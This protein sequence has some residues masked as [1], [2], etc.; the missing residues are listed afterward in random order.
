MFAKAA[1]KHPEKY[2]CFNKFSLLRTDSLNSFDSC[3]TPV[4]V[5][6]NALSSLSSISYKTP[7]ES[8]IS[9]ADCTDAYQ[10]F[11]ILDTRNGPDVAPSIQ[12][13]AE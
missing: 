4:S 11:I 9:V 1:V 13:G 7:N 6:I 12:P 2:P 5:S 3:S 8:T 10:F